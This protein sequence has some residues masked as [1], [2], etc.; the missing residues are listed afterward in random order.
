MSESYR[1][2][3]SEEQH[4]RLDAFFSKG[5]FQAHIPYFPSCW[6][7]PKDIEVGAVWKPFSVLLLDG[8]FPNLSFSPCWIKA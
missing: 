1:W 6:A 8:V 2:S 5:K 4:G 3:D 7:Y